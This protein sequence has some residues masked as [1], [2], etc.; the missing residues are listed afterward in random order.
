MGQP[1][2]VDVAA[3]LFQ[4]GF[5]SARRNLEDGGYEHLTF[6]DKPD[7]LRARTNLDDG[8]RWEIHPVFRQALQMRD[9]QGRSLR[10]PPTDRR[11]R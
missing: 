9:A 2:P 4:I 6:A 10:L 8:V 7:L 1:R 5:L 3:F 11:G